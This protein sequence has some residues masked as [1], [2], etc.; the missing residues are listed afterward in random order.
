MVSFRRTGYPPSLTHSLALPLLAAVLL[1]SGFVAPNATAQVSF[2]GIGQLTGGSPIRSQ[3]NAVSGDGNVVAGQ[4]VDSFGTRAIVWTEL[5]GLGAFTAGGG[6]TVGDAAYGLDFDGNVVGGVS[7]LFRLTDPSLPISGIFYGSAHLWLNGVLTPISGLD[8][9]GPSI[10]TVRDVSADGTIAVGV[11]SEDFTGSFGTG[12]EKAFRRFSNGQIFSLGLL[13]GYVGS[14]ATG[15]SGDGSVITGFSSFGFTGEAFRWTLAGGMQGL[16]IL[17]NT[18]LFPGSAAFGISADGTT[19]VG[20]TASSAVTGV[21]EAFRWRQAT[22]MVGLG[23]FGSFTGSSA[24]AASSDG[25]RIVG[26]LNII[27]FT[28]PPLNVAA[29]YDDAYG[30]LFP[31]LPLLET[32]LGPLGGWELTEATG[33]SDDG[34]VVVGNGLNPLGQE[35]GWI[36]VLPV[37]EPTVALSL[38]LGALLTAGLGTWRRARS[39]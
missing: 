2:Q 3:A 33:V 26:T 38:P 13:P 6:V 10:G 23:V 29:V 21:S 11:D 31:I 20:S 9:G 34:T 32:A 36:A 7:N 30:Q 39:G 1:M 35:E 16:G 17:P 24:R 18:A 8:P 28:D 12:P 27:N 15:I 37:P 14:E 22:D 5:G 19:I 4:A 25:S